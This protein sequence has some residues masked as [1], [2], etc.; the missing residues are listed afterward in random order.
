MIMKY[1]LEIAYD[2]TGYSGWQNQ[3]DR[4]SIQQIIEEKLSYLY[5]NQKI[6]V[7]GAGRTDAG[8]HALGMTA[9]FSPPVKPFIAPEKLLKAMNSILPNSIHINNIQTAE[10]E[11]NARFNAVGKAYTYVICKST[12]P[13]PFLYNW[14]YSSNRILITDK[15]R[16]ATKYLLGEHDFSS[17]TVELSKTKKNPVRKIYRIEVDEFDNF[18]CVTFI[19]KSFLYKMIRSLMGTLIHVGEGKTEPR[20]VKEILDSKDRSKAHI[21]ALPNGLYLMKVF[22]KEEAMRKFHLTNLPFYSR[23]DFSDENPPAQ[24]S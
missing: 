21:T 14:C 10:S 8:V 16:E 5:A 18:I 24:T 2:G 3:P 20:K 22:Y 15:L 12:A 7:K 9:S 4:I 1:K 17:F 23:P 19:G 11:F 13:G 6:S